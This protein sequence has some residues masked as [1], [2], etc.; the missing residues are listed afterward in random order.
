MTDQQDRLAALT[1][2]VFKAVVASHLDDEDETADFSKDIAVRL[3][4]AGVTAPPASQPPSGDAP[5]PLEV[6]KDISTILHATT[7]DRIFTDPK[8]ELR[9][10]HM[11]L[12]FDAGVLQSNL[13]CKEATLVLGKVQKRVSCP[14]RAYTGDILTIIHEIELELK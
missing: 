4:A 6:G 5:E 7:G 8:I 12:W 3:I 10:S 9:G 14:V 1:D 13:F 2:L 11:R